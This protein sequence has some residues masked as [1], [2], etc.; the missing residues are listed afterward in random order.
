MEFELEE[1]EEEGIEAHIPSS[2]P[3]SPR[4]S[5]PPESSGEG[6]EDMAG[7]EGGK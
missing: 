3:P 6:V 2:P 1:V 7:V 4:H 5:P